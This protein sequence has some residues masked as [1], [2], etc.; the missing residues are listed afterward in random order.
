MTD[1]DTPGAFERPPGFRLR[2]ELPDA[3]WTAGADD[4]VVEV[5]FDAEVAWW[6]RRQVA[7][8]ASTITEGSDGGITV[9]LPVAQVDAFIGWLISFDDHAEILAPAAIRDRFVTHVV[10]S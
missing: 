9:H 3:P 4:V 1:G 2:D 6:A 7:A 10:G 8:A 5:A